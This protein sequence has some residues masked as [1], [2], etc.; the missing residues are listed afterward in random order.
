MTEPGPYGAPRARVD[1]AP[2]PVDHRFRW[3]AVFIGAA[4]DLGT[5]T[6]AGIAI[7]LLFSVA[8]AA[9]GLTTDQLLA[10]LVGYWPFLLVSMVVGAGCTV[11]G[12]Y[13]AARIARQRFLLHALAAGV[14]SLVLGI[15]LFPQDN[16]PYAGLMA[17]IGYGL[18]LPL[19]IFGGYLARAFWR[20]RSG[21]RVSA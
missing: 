21:I 18:H 13:V 15:L 14:M 9:E 2:Q 1:D 12:G 16:G 6:A 19:A 17:L 4:A 10:Q 3:K 8:F 7:F 20:R 11:L 5:S